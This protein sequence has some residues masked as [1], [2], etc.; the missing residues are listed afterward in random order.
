[1]IGRDTNKR[2]MTASVMLGAAL[3]VW[4]TSSVARAA[5]PVTVT[6]VASPERALRFEVIV[7]GSLDEV[8]AAFT[9]NDGLAAWLWRDVRVDARPGGDWLAL[10]PGST[11]GGTIV[12]LAP[13]Q[14]LVIAALAPD[15]FPTVRKERT[16]AAFAFAAVTPDS[17]KVTLVQTGWKAGDEWDAAYDYLA[18]GNAELLNQLYQRFVTGPVVWPKGR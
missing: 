9:T 5:G 12:S 15:R 14:Q 16:R 1:M 4:T 2:M 8:W 10:F 17:T 13:K 11:G 7:P 18:G 3:L 6:R